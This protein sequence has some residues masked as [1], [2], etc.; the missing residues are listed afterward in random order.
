VRLASTQGEKPSMRHHYLRHHRARMV[1]PLVFVLFGC[2][3]P[4]YEN[5]LHSNYGA[6]EFRMDLARCRDQ[7]ATV[8]VNTW[9]YMQ[10]GSGVDEV[11]ANACM[12]T[13]G[14]QQAPPSV[15]VISGL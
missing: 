6:N 4:L 11:K 15:S 3:P 7:S 1:V 9:G 10:S 12:A 13:Q 2:S 5:S 14:W 8:V